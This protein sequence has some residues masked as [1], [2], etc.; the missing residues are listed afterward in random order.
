M[1]NLAIFDEQV[2]NS[3]IRQVDVS[4]LEQFEDN[5]LKRLTKSQFNVLLFYEI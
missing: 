3:K 4:K 1:P 2:H 5:R